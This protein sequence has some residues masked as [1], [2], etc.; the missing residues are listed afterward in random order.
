MARGDKGKLQQAL[1][2]LTWP[3]ISELTACPL[4]PSL[5]LPGVS[6]PEKPLET[7]SSSLSFITA[8]KLN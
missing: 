1:F 3:G 7:L 2:L 6:I 5:L 4:D 8:S